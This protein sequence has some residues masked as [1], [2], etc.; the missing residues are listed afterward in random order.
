MGW[1][2]ASKSHRNNSLCTALQEICG[3]T[4]A[5][6]EARHTVPHPHR[7]PPRESHAVDTLNIHLVACGE[8]ARA[9]ASPLEATESFLSCS[10]RR[11]FGGKLKLLL[12]DEGLEQGTYTH[13]KPGFSSPAALWTTGYLLQVSAL[14]MNFHNETDVVLQRNCTNNF[15]FYFGRSMR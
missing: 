7:H 6:R 11:N 4:P 15:Q 14:K 12:R 8:A 3:Q 13:G 9:S 2:K 1:V 10:V 5:S